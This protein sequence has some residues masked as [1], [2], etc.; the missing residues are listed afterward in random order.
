MSSEK[1][2]EK[3][4]NE[5]EGVGTD[6][7]IINVPATRLPGQKSKEEISFNNRLGW[8]PIKI[9]DLPTRG[10]FYPDGTQISVKAATTA[11]IRHWST[12]NESDMSQTDD[13]LNYII[14]RCVSIKFPNTSASSWK[15]LKEVD[16]FYIILAAQELTFVDG[17]NKLQVDISEGK[18]VDVTKDMIDYINFSEKIMKYYNKDK[19][20]FTIT[21]KS[22]K[23]MDVHIPSVGVVSWLKQYTQRKKQSQELMDEDFLSYAPFVIKDW[24][25]L[26]ELSY[27]E[28][29]NESFRWSVT[30]ISALV[31]IRKMFI[32]TVN[33]V[34]KYF[35]E[36]GAEKFA[37][38]SFRGGIKGIFIISDPFDEL[39]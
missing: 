36:G 19:K 7:P 30:E 29:V 2:L 1:E 8:V 15:D 6:R 25:G 17:E 34:I 18:K 38:L 32:E 3:F 31:Q 23:T 28:Y 11:E 20:C 9:E 14:E 12:L 37:P 22:G 27:S 35:D 13:M 16:R 4:V 5:Q 26:N 39:G 10:L 33:P 21:F 24:K